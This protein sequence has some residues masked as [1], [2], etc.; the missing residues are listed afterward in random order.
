[1]AWSERERKLA[2]A[3]ASLVIVVVLVTGIRGVLSWAGGSGA[4]DLALGAEGLGDLVNTLQDID[5]LRARNVDLKKRLGNEGMT[6]IDNTKVSDLLK[7]IEQTGRRAGLR[8][9]IFDPTAR[10]KSKPLPSLE[11]KV[12][13]ECVFNQLVQFLAELEKPEISIFVRDM[14]TG[15]KN[16]GQPQLSVTMTLVTYLVT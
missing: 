10:P 3:T 1:M 7:S 9:T 15:L 2:G 14:R 6:C 11:V 13:F 12:T 5:A 16:E 8:I 4:R